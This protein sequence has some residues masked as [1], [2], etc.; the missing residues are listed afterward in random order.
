MKAT[1]PETA[2][3][4]PKPRHATNATR[5]DTSYVLSPLSPSLT[6]LTHNSPATAPNPAV[7]LGLTAAAV[8]AT[9][10]EAAAPAT[11]AVNQGTLRVRALKQVL[12]AAAALLR[13]A[14]EEEREEGVV[15]R[16]AIRVEVLGI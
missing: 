10:L 1:F 5:P 4:K 12:A 6:N 16:R 2:P 11:S 15:I 3:K 14:E 13:L 7:A 8:V 9:P